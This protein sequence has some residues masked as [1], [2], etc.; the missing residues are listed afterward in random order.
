MNNKLKLIKRSGYTFIT[1][2]NFQ[3]ISLLN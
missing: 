3:L 2:H 1:F